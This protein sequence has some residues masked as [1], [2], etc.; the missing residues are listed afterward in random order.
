MVAFEHERAFAHTHTHVF[1]QM[2][3]LTLR[4][5]EHFDNPI[6]ES[7]SPED[8]ATAL[9]VGHAAVAHLRP[10]RSPRLTGQC[11]VQVRPGQ[12]VSQEVSRKCLGRG[13]T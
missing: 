11:A 10:E 8:R 5:P 6:P 7:W 1:S 3:L 2:Q 9:Q 13:V 4:L 12:E